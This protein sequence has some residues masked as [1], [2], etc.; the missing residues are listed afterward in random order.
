MTKCPDVKIDRL[1]AHT[2]KLKFLASYYLEEAERNESNPYYYG[3][4]S[5]F[6]DIVKDLKEV[7][8]QIVELQNYCYFLEKGC[9]PY[10][11]EKP[12]DQG[13]NAGGRK[14]RSG[15]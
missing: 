1:D 11:K 9:S 5:N 4:C 12:Q 10:H 6:E 2:D 8:N 3:L 15:V 14:P 7:F 13:V